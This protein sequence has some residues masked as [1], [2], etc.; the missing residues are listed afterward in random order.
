MAQKNKL[1]EA[2]E[3]KRYPQE[4]MARIISKDVT[5]YCRKEKGIIRISTEEWKELAKALEMP[6][7]DIYEPDDNAIVIFNDNGSCG[8]NFVG[9]SVINYSIPQSL[10][11][12]Q[13][14]YCEKVE[15]ENRELK[16]KNR[17]LEEKNRELEEKI[18]HLEEK[19]QALQSQS[20]HPSV[21]LVT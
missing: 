18:R 8:G 14:K 4:Y 7:A 6:L 17:E 16:D 13:K 2:R 10:L 1:I 11:D 9:E 3:L 21:P 5:T 20:Q 12:Y 19:N 15:E